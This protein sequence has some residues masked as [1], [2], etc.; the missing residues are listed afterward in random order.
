MENHK[1]RNVTL[2]LTEAEIELFDELRHVRA[3]VAGCPISRS[4]ILME[5]LE[6][7]YMTVLE[8]I[9]AAAKNYPLYSHSE[10]TA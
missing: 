9:T 8:N 6:Y 5:A 4:A 2:R 3:L 1:K 7:G 10:N